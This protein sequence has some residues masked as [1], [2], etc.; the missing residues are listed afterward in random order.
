MKPQLAKGTAVVVE[1]EWLVRM[2][3]SDAL[4]ADG[5]TTIELGSGEA[6]LA[7]AATAEKI[8]VLVTDIRLGGMASGW[9][10]AEA[11][12]ARHPAV[13]VIYASGN[14][15]LANRKVADSAF[16]SKPVKIPDL[17]VLANA[18]QGQSQT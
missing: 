14:T 9:D 6:A 4:A 8:D 7:F 3:L 17:V 13:R 15:I 2:E 11:F 1:D 5:W 12:R 18:R 16:L 10:V